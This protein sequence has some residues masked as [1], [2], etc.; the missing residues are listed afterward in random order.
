MPTY[1]IIDV[2][3]DENPVVTINNLNTVTEDEIHLIIHEKSPFFSHPAYCELL[4]REA[5][6]LG[7]TLKVFLPP[8][9]SGE[10]FEKVGI[11][12][13]K[14]GA[15]AGANFSSKG[16]IEHKRIVDISQP[17]FTFSPIE[18][19]ETPDEIEINQEQTKEL[20]QFLEK[21]KEIKNKPYFQIPKSKPF[22][23]NKIYLF[24]AATIAVLIFLAFNYLPRAK[25]TL[26]SA[27]TDVKA[28]I[29]FRIDKNIQTYDLAEKKVPGQI[30][31]IDFSKSAEFP[32]SALKNVKEKAKG[33]VLMFNDSQSAQSL[34]PLRLE[35]P[36]GK[37][38]WTDSSITIK[39]N[40]SVEVGITASSPGSEYNLDCSKEK[41]CNFVIL[42]WKDKAKGKQI[43]GR[44]ESD[45]SGGLIGEGK[46][47]TDAQIKQ[48]KESLENTW[49]KEGVEQLKTKLLSGIKVLD[50]KAFSFNI[51]E[52]KSDVPPGSAA[53]KFNLLIRGEISTVAVKESDV[54]EFIDKIIQSNIS[55]DKITYPDKMQIFYKD[56]AI[57]PETGV[58]DVKSEVVAEI[59]YKFDS[60][61]IKKEIA[62]KSPEELKNYLNAL[63]ES[64]KA[65]GQAY[66]WPKYIARTV[67]QQLER[68]VVEIK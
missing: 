12:V 49:K 28:E 56:I 39:P 20:N 40:S 52:V 50:D 10:F 29:S 21:S 51:K 19:L 27:R 38:Y 3:Q 31:K 4:K 60:L 6:F 14:I 5:D 63:K 55:S 58:M 15:T 36:N 32:V 68:I 37:I 26:I 33:K 1:K 7:K 18:T 65:T 44:A 42:L 48:A 43:Y 46:I 17:Q 16:P 25:I 59:G 23:S 34:I 67:P 61:T 13:E 30:V 2:P 53:D 11:F 54:A 45:I 8:E 66:L 47:V 24:G 35:G 64:G 9:S 62:G 41:P 57:N 22:Y